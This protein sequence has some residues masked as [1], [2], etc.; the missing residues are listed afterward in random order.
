MRKGAWLV[1]AALVAVG[2]TAYAAVIEQ[3]G[4][5]H[6]LPQGT[7]VHGELGELLDDD[8]TQYCLLEGRLGGQIVTGGTYASENLDFES[9]S[10]ATKGAVRVLETT[11]ASDPTSGA[12]QVFGGM[13]VSENLYVGGF[14]GVSGNALFQGE[15]SSPGAGANSERFGAGAVA[16]GANSVAFGNAASAGQN[17]CVILGAGADCVGSGSLSVVV[18]EGARAAHQNTVTIGDDSYVDGIQSVGVGALTSTRA[19]DSLALGFSATTNSGGTGQICIGSGCSTSIDNSISI[20]SAA[21]PVSTLYLG[22]G[23]STASPSAS[24]FTGSQASGANVAGGD[25]TYAGGQGTGSATG[26]YISFKTAAAGGAGSSVNALA[27][28]ARYTVAGDHYMAVASA[29]LIMKSP[30]GTCSSCGPD[31]SDVWSCTGVSCP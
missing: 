14:F 25:V 31:D 4:I 16:A 10:H 1:T 17:D 13:G 2:F 27:E 3:P 15:I 6:A 9:T 18:G 23:P 11:T 5:G 8:H 28:I 12:F 22:E 21:T 19:A 20:G 29:K 30:D 24:V 26:G 7:I